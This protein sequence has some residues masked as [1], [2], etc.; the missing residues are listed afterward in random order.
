MKI[1]IL[2]GDNVIFRI[3]PQTKDQRIA[4]VQPVSAFLHVSQECNVSDS[5][6]DKYEPLA[7][8]EVRR[9]LSIAVLRKVYP[10]ELQRE[11]YDIRLAVLNLDPKS[12]NFIKEADA[13]VDRLGSLALTLAPWKDPCLTAQTA[14]LNEHHDPI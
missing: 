8:Y 14:P 4:G 1:P 11:I 5:A 2:N 7:A 12:W 6:L 9:I 10:I 13:I 3:P